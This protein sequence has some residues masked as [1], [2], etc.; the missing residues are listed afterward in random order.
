LLYTTFSQR[1]ETMKTYDLVAACNGFH[2]RDGVCQ[3]PAIDLLGLDHEVDKPLIAAVA[4]AYEANRQWADR[5]DNSAACGALDAMLEFG[6]VDG[7]AVHAAIH[8]AR[9][10]MQTSGPYVYPVE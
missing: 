8:R 2:D 3:F 7:D 9:K 10:V 1:S 4:R 5:G 6:V